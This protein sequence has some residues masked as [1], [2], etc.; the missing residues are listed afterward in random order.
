MH[1]DEEALSQDW[2]AAEA[3]LGHAFSVPH[4]SDDVTLEESVRL[5]RYLD[6]G[7]TREERSALEDQLAT[8][9]ALRR[10]LAAIYRELAAITATL[11]H[12][13]LAEAHLKQE[14]VHI[15]FDEKTSNPATA[16]QEDDTQTIVQQEFIKL[17]SFGG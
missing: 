2:I 6:G 14:I 4:G 11:P 17:R 9:P 16:P 5:A 15:A 13:P 1:M 8:R 3:L 7:M 12:E 10:A